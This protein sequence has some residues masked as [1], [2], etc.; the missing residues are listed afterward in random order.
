MGYCVTY[1][2]NRKRDSRFRRKYPFLGMTF[3]FFALFCVVA[4]HYFRQELVMLYQIL[5]ADLPV[6]SLIDGLRSGENFVDSVAAFCEDMLHG[7]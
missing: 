7:H 6:E 1:G 4:Q 3:L 5:F 2:T